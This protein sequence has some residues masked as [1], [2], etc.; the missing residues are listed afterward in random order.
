MSGQDKQAICHFLQQQ[1]VLTLAV[2]YQGELWCANCFYVFNAPQMTFYLM[3]D[4]ESRHGK[5]MQQNPVISGTVAH[6]TENIA[7]IQGVQYQGEIYGLIGR[8]EKEA[9]IAYYQRFPNAKGVSAPLWGIRLNLLKMTS[10]RKVFAQ[11]VFWHRENGLKS[12]SE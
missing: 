10:N 1:Y 4:A 2:S 8:E 7:D 9:K 6:Q 5:L 3:T 11:K 12:A